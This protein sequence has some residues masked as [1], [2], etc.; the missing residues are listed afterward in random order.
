MPASGKPFIRFMHRHLLCLI[1]FALIWLSATNTVA[2][3]KSRN[4]LEKERKENLRKIEQSR[5]DL[6]AVKREKKSSLSE[7]RDLEEKERLKEKTIVSIRD[8]LGIL[9]SDIVHLES[10]EEKLA[11]T[12]MRLKKE[13]AAMIYAASKAGKNNFILYLLSSESI[14]RL[15]GRLNQ[16][17]H[18]SEDRKLQEKQI[19]AVSGQLNQEKLKLAEARQG[20]EILLGREQEERKKLMA[21]EKD[22]Q[23]LLAQLSKKE[24]A[25]KLKIEKHQAALKKLESLIA[26]LVRKEIRKSRNTNKNS[27]KKTNETSNEILLTP[28]GRI[29]SSSFSGNQ[30]RLA[31][32]VESGYISSGFGKHEH[33]ALK[34]VYVDNLGIDITTRPGTSVRAVFDGVIGLIGSVPGMD[35]KIIMIRHGDYFTVYSGLTNIRVSAGEKVKTKTILGEIKSGSEGPVLQ[36]Q[37]WKNDKRLNPQNWLAKK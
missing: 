32:P 21:L 19:R 2:Q 6:K 35:G 10:E 11:Y 8:E 24:I 3:K 23:E 28:E 13:Y 34:R 9:E 30:G 29:L 20:K 5:L 18:Y 36:F 12:L 33:P 15:F 37:V 4:Q 22:K 14:N 31:W 17:K 1:L 16:L 7:L 25:L 26:S 27:N